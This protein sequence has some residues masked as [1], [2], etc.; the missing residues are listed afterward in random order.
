MRQFFVWIR[1]PV[2]R[3]NCPAGF[4]G[5]TCEQSVLKSP[6]PVAATECSVGYTDEDNDPSTPCVKCAHTWQAPQTGHTGPCR[7]CANG[8]TVRLT[9]CECPAGYYG[10]RCEAKE[11]AWTSDCAAGTTDDDFDHGSPCVP[12]GH[13]TYVPASSVGPCSGFVCAADTTD[14]DFDASTP[15]IACASG[16]TAAASGWS[17]A[18]PPLPQCANGGTVARGGNPLLGGRSHLPRT[19]SDLWGLGHRSDGVYEVWPQ[20]SLASPSVQVVCDMTSDDAGRGPNQPNGWMLVSHTTA[21]APVVGGTTSGPPLADQVVS[22]I[23]AP[24]VGFG[25]SALDGGNWHRF[26]WYEYSP[27][28]M[29]MLQRGGVFESLY[30]E[31]TYGNRECWS[32]LPEGLQEEYTEL[33]AVDGFGVAMKYVHVTWSSGTRWGVLR[34]MTLTR[35]GVWHAW[36]PDGHSI[37]P[38]PSRTTHGKRC[39]AMCQFPLQTP[40]SHGSLRQSMERRTQPI[41]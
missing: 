4:S 36:P 40:A 5:P 13:G 24:G 29:S 27:S 20:G 16:T 30:G 11:A 6:C 12:C 1:I 32:R 35:H 23:V 8:G 26:W 7:W 17:G 22:S 41:M 34:C 37:P 21:Y 10:E 14:E 39:M 25:T 33:L 18:C 38:T 19:C 2:V 3:C 9:G 28:A 31:C 15:C